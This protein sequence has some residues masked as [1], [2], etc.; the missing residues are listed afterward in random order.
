M[1]V[2]LSSAQI[3]RCGELL[4]QYR[5]LLLGIDFALLSIARS[6][7]LHLRFDDFSKAS[8]RSLP[9]AFLCAIEPQG[10]I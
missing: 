7:M 8:E 1:L 6:P 3:G 2:T 4:V 9:P 10:E 5:L